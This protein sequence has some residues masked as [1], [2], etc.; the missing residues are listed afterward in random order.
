MFYLQMAMVNNGDYGFWHIGGAEVGDVSWG[1]GFGGGFDTAMKE[2]GGYENP[3]VIS[4]GAVHT[5]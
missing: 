1:N 4:L 2:E 5:F 3:M